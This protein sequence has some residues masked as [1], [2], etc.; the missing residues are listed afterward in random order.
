[1]KYEPTYFSL[2]L[3]PSVTVPHRDA[4]LPPLLYTGEYW[5][6]TFGFQNFQ[7][8]KWLECLPKYIKVKVEQSHYRPGQALR[9]PGG[10]GP[11]FQDNRHLKVIRLSA[12]RTD[13]LYPHKTFLFLISVRGWVNPRIIVR[14]EVLWQWKIS[15]TSSRIEPSTFRLVAQYLNQLALPRAPT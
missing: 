6:E 3:A 13:R 8:N 5:K 9:I 4:C 1:V 12:L 15:M 2:S 10:W 14:S 7:I 11:I